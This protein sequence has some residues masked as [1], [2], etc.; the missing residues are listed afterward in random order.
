MRTAITLLVLLVLLAGTPPSLAKRSDGYAL[1]RWTVDGGGVTF[2]TGEGYTL[3]G[4]AGQPDA[5][6]WGDGRYS[7]GGGFWGAIVTLEGYG[8]YLPVVLRGS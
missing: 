4:T 5:A 1:A 2:I 7:L 3:G 8:I 6:S